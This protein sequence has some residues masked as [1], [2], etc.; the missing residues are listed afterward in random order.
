MFKWNRPKVCRFGLY[1]SM[2]IQGCFKDLH[3]RPIGFPDEEC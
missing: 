1:Q 3:G 2:G